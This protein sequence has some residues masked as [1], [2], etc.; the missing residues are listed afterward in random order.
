MGSAFGAN[1][2]RIIVVDGDAGRRHAL[3]EALTREGL[4]V[5]GASTG[6]SGSALAR[7][8]C[9][10]AVVLNVALPHIDGLVLVRMLRSVTYIPIV[11]LGSRP[12]VADRVLALE[13]GAD[14]YLVKPCDVS[15]L[16]ARL[17]KTMHRP[18]LQCGESRRYADLELDLA[19][20]QARRG[21][22]TA[23]LTTKE[24]QL[25]RVLIE[26]P[27]RVFTRDQL[28]DIVWGPEPQVSTSALDT[29]LSGLRAKID[30]PFARPLIRTVRGFGYTLR[31]EPTGRN[32]PTATMR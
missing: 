15:E 4:F 28:L 27:H 20:R 21:S 10:H 26:R 8:W 14:D 1:Q 31:D 32:G 30:A 9:P 6:L 23:L 12:D 24:T 11:V 2:G 29:L 17:Q 25:L 18:S 22:A 5:R 13:A 16:A 3:E 19:F 7:E